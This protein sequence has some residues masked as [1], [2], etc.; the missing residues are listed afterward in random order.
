MRLQAIKRKNNQVPNSKYTEDH[1]TVDQLIHTVEKN[2]KILADAKKGFFD[3][4]K[5]AKEELRAAR[6]SK[7]SK[8][9]YRLMQQDVKEVLNDSKAR[10][11]DLEKTI[12]NDIAGARRQHKANEAKLERFTKR[13]W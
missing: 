7:I 3:D 5:A 12:K 4:R 8:E 10:I 2:Q 13:K 11:Q 9:Q 1:R 6:K